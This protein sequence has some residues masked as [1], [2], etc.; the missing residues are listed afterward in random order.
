MKFEGTL[1]FR[2][3]CKNAGKPAGVDVKWSD[4]EAASKSK[5][6]EFG[7][8]SLPLTMTFPFWLML[9]TSFPNV[10]INKKVAAVFSPEREENCSG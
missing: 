3:A 5:T 2:M 10:T 7:S 1:I 9:I 6:F 8:K 4:T